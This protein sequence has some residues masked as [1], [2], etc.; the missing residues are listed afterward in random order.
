M[1]PAGYSREYGGELRKFVQE[2]SSMMT[3]FALAIIIIYLVLC[4]Q[5]ESFRDPL[6][7]MM[8]VPLSIAGAMVFLYLGFA[9]VNIYTQVGLI[10]LVGLITKHGILIVEFANKL[11][12]EKNYGIRQAVEHAA[13]VRLRPILMTTAAMVL[14]VLPLVFAKGAG[15]ESRFCIGLVISTGMSI[16]TLFTLF[17]VP[18]FYVLLAK[19]RRPVAQVAT[20]ELNHGQSPSSH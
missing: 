5:F 13:S 7:I 20:A 18:A 11:Q 16:G 2:G 4:A 3:V 15:S 10:T 14:G 8:S 1:L 19:D 17:I 6:I 12:E 9:T